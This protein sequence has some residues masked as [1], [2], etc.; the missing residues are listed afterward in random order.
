MPL[1]QEA[2]IS[3]GF[4]VQAGREIIAVRAR[5]LGGFR[6]FA[7][8]FAYRKLDNRVL[9]NARAVARSVARLGAPA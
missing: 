5:C 6:V 2:I 8:D 1:E 3:A 4:A 9:P 7:S